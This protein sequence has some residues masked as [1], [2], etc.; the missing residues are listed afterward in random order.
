MFHVFAALD[1]FE[2]GVIRKH[3]HAGLNATCASLAA[4]TGALLHAEA[5]CPADNRRAARTDQC[6]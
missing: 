1:E 5:E 2:R 6:L 3:T 4:Q